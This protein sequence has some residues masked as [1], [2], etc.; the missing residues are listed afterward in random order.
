MA[1]PKGGADISWFVSMANKS[2]TLASVVA[3]LK[4]IKKI[5]IAGETITAGQTIYKDGV[6][7]AKLKLADSNVAVRSQVAGIAPHGASNNQPLSYAI[8]DPNFTPG[9]EVTIGEI[10][11]A[12]AT[13]G[14]IAPAADLTTG[15]YPTV[16]G[17]GKSEP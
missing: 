5:G 4:A 16:L 1:V 6:N 15:D 7:S 14:S 12:S 11:V 9:C 3:S 13:P 2:I 8:E 10:L 17:I